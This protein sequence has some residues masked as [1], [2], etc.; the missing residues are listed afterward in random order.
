[1][2]DAPIPADD[3]ERVRRLREYEILDTD[4]DPQFDAITRLVAVILEVPI[5]LVSL[6]DADRQWFKS[7]HGLAARETPRSVSFCGHVVADLAPMVVPDAVADARF[8]DNPLV[9]GEPRVRFYAGYPLRTRDGVVLGTLCAIDHAPRELSPVQLEA[10]GLLAGQ[11]AALLELRHAGNTLRAERQLGEEREAKLAD[12]ERLLATVFDGMVEGVVLQDRTGAILHHNPAAAAIL[13]LSRD[14]LQGRTSIDPRW[15]A[16]R[17]DGS[18]FPGDDHPAMVTLRTGEP[19]SDVEMCIDVPAGKRRWISI[20]SR[21]IVGPGT[22]LP[23]AVVTTFHDISERRDVAQRLAQH[24]R[25]VTTGTLAAGVGHEINNPLTVALANLALAIEELE[26]IEG[27]S[28]SQRLVEIIGLLEQARE[29]GERVKRIVRGLKSLAREE[30]D[31]LPIDANAVV[32][33]A[34]EM[35]SHE[36]RTQASVELDLSDAPLVQADDSRLAQVLINLIVNA[37]Q[38]FPSSDPAQNRIMIRTRVEGQVIIEV[39]DNGPGIE[40]SVLAR[41]F[42]PF[43]TTRQVGAGSGLGLAISHGIITAFG[44]TLTCQTVVGEGTTFRIAL[45]LSAIP[46]APA[47]EIVQSPT[48]GSMLVVD[49][50]PAILKSMVRMFRNELEVVAVADP[51]EALRLIQAGTRFD[52]VFCDLTMPYLSGMEL[53]DTVAATHPQIADRFVFISGD[54]SRADI[55]QFMGRVRNERIEK[56]FSIQ[57]LRA[58]VRRLVPNKT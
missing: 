27:R 3:A 32:R 53:F 51:R 43:F 57:N 56:P 37:A 35:A 22:S 26:L 45:P 38:A 2:K 31:L 46:A 41:I 48:R 28:P 10:L 13:G 20:N 44:G 23:Y 9:T 25:L 1:M 55:R 14:Q 11:V 49:D 4:A 50:E 30:K 18:P 6:V 8:A 54:L 12:R 36:L 7:R 16:T 42:D 58:I 21:P 52:V 29:G 5:A 33:S 40:P 17:G 15:R 39:A 24:Q 34:L 19:L 47:A